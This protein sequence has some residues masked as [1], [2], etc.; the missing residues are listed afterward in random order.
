MIR[1]VAS[2]AFLLNFYAHADVSV[3]KADVPV[4]P[5]P[6]Y[7]K[8]DFCNPKDPDFMEYR[9]K[10]RVPTCIRDVSWARKAQVYGEYKIPQKCWKYYT[11]DHYIPLFMGGSNKEVNLWPEHKDVKATRQNLEQ[12]LYEQMK[13]GQISQKRAIDVITHAKQHPPHVIPRGCR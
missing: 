12:E 11:V 2:A 7:T 4:K 9:Y 1:F 3:T 8:G 6:E 5:N 13:G 10:E